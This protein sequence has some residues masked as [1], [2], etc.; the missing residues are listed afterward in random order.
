MQLHSDAGAETVFLVPL[1]SLRLV[2]AV[3]FLYVLSNTGALGSQA[4]QKC[5]LEDLLLHMCWL[6]RG[7]MWDEHCV[8]E[9]DTSRS[10]L[11]SVG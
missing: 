3:A 11:I 2:T 1:W 10:L 6:Q 4:P 9:S 8:L 5:S 7:W